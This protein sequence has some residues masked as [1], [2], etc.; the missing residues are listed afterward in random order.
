MSCKTC[1][2]TSVCIKSRSCSPP[3]VDKLRELHSLLESWSIKPPAI[4]LPRLIPETRLE[5][6]IRLRWDKLGVRAILVSFYDL[7][8]VNIEKVMDEGVHRFLDFDGT[9]LLS[10]ITLDR[11][12]TERTF[13][14][15]LALLKDGGF[16]GVVGWDMPVY[17]DDPKMMS[18]TNL[19]SAALF[20]AR[21]VRE[22][23]PTI[24][25]LK[26][27]DA[28]EM[29]LY[30]HWLQRL[31]FKQVALHATEYVLN[32]EDEKA[33]DLMGTAVLKM[34][35]LR[36]K[37]LIIGTASPRSLPYGLCREFPE[38]SF[39]GMGWLLSAERFHAYHG[40]DT[41]DLKACV[42]ECNCQACLGKPATRVSRS[43]EDIAEHNLIQLKNL[44]GG[45]KVGENIGVFDAVLEHGTTAVV[46]DL[47]IGTNQS[48]W[49]TCLEKLKK[50]RPSYVI[51]LGDTFDYVNGSP[52]LWEV[53]SFM[54]GLRELKAEVIPVSGCSD[55]DRLKLLE[56]MKQLLF[57]EDS[58]RPQLLESNDT[59]SGA[60]RDLLAFHS[61]CKEEIRVKLADG[62]VIVLR[63]GHRLGFNKEDDLEE[64]VNGILREEDD[65]EIHVLGHFHKSF[66]KPKKRLV[67]LG[68]WQTQTREEEKTGFIPD[69][70][71]ILLIKGDGSLK[72]VRGE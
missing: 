44:I 29:D 36:V 35:K 55:S 70:M 3:K 56:A 23:V 62:R 38:A 9:V 65:I 24:P 22:G 49:E 60:V 33:R 14:L 64:I 1:M 41:L 12:L 52:T 26:G 7:E 34:I 10:T 30:S 42:M 43:V 51:L 16:D 5:K 45:E 25:L 4:E 72:L 46:A 67:I 61:A 59:R 18:L 13:N 39:A 32:Y 47:H 48:L 40:L 6:P 15:T 8:K 53:T 50:I 69:I 17:M 37:P 11:L 63:H 20:T 66:F 28:K 27:S 2:Y 68:S 21:Y 19:I 58:I 54:N 31:G 71:D 57:T